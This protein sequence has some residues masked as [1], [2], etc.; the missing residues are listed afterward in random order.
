MRCAGLPLLFVLLPALAHEAP[1]GGG[2][3]AWR[4]PAYECTTHDGKRYESVDADGNPRWVSAWAIDLPVQAGGNTLAVT[5]GRVRMG[6]D[7]VALR[8]P[9]PRAPWPDNAVLRVRDECRPLE[10]VEVC[11]RVEERLRLVGRRHFNA[12][13]SER[14]VLKAE[15]RALQAWLGGACA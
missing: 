7:G 10:R 4:P 2:P 13:P 11:E 9:P 3:A 1:A 15:R 5:G 6:G 14:A 12:Q 8:S